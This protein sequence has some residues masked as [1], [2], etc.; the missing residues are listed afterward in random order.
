[1][2]AVLMAA[3]A[4][5]AA[6]GAAAAT[7]P[8]VREIMQA[9]HDREDGDNMSAEVT[10][11]LV[12]NNGNRTM[13]HL[14]AYRKDFGT[15]AFHIMY[16]LA[17]VE[18]K[19]AGLLSYDYT[20]PGKADDQWLFMPEM[21]KAHRIARHEKSRGFLGSDFSFSDVTRQ[22]LASHR[23]RLMKEPKINGVPMWQIEVLP[24]TKEVAVESGYSKSMLWV[25]K[26]NLVAVRAV[27]W[28]HNSRRIKH[29]QVTRL[30]LID[31]IWVAVEVQMITKDGRNTLHATLLQLSNIKFNEKLNK[32]R[33]TVRALER[34]LK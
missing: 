1:M 8:D 24:S 12:D 13:R 33:F 4:H 31:G 17:P 9:V 32:R 29:V 30:A 10:M 26:D 34:G 15:A 27:K 11:I 2:I 20:A 7:K 22:D 21:K 5:P 28:L 16:G 19:D 25:R 3:V 14:R 6:Q 23:Y 18:I